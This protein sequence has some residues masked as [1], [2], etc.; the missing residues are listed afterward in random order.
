MRPSRARHA[1][2]WLALLSGMCMTSP[3]RAQPTPSDKALA[4]GLFQDGKKLMD[5]GKLPEACPKLAESQRVDPT[6]GTLLNLAVCHE[7]EGKTA[8]AWAEFKEASALAASAGQQD[9]AQFAA[10]RGSEL[11]ARLTRLVLEVA[12][13]APGMAIT[14]NGKELSATAATGSGIPVDP[15]TATV[16]ARAPGKQPWSQQVTLDPGPSTARV[17]IPPLAGVAAPEPPRAAPPAPPRPAPPARPEARG[18]EGTGSPMRALGFVAGGVGLAGIGVGAVF[19][20]LTV[21]KASDVEEGCS[22]NFRCSRADV[23]ANESA[24]TTAM[25]SNIAVGAGLLCLGAGVAM[26]LL[27]PSPERAVAGERVWVAPSVA[28]DGGRV[29]LGGQW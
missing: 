15:G 2:A 18:P 4:E 29:V 12:Q 7:K 8:S 20:V 14:L 11:E 21:Q 22:G 24:R 5:E 28:S 17:T 13:P 16:E 3:L 26:V 23:E 9:R 25:V 19:G 10:K 1:G 6:V 27:S